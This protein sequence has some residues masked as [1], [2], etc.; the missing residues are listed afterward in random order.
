MPAS[1][2]LSHQAAIAASSVLILFKPDELSSGEGTYL[3][4]VKMI[5]LLVANG[6]WYTLQPTPPSVQ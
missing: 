1:T 5:F 4:Q 6:N 3:N 2:A